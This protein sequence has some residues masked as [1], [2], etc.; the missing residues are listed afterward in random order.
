MMKVV[1]FLHHMTHIE[2]PSAVAIGNFDGMH[3]GHQAILKN[4]KDQAA[5][6]NWSSVV[7]LFEPHPKE[8][9][10]PNSSPP[11][12][13]RLT[14]KLLFLAEFG[15]DL[16]ICLKFDSK[17]ADLS[18]THFVEKIL[19]DRLKVSYLSVGEDF[20]F[21]RG[22]Q[23]NVSFL[24]QTGLLNKFEVVT[25]ST[26]FID[27]T[28]TR[29]SST[30]IRAC[31]NQG[32]LAEARELLGHPL[33]LSGRVVHGERRGREMGFPTANISLNRQMAYSGVFAVTTN[34]DG[35]IFKGVANI[36][37][38]PTIHPSGKNRF[39]EIYFFDF[40]GD[41]YGKRLQVEL[42]QKIRDEVRF[43]SLEKLK[44]QILDDVQSAK[45]L[46]K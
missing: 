38:R 15:I 16:V 9:F 46:L 43:E 31:I 11:R 35:K 8:Y 29:I 17:L 45:K 26:I 4:I 3:L 6:H 33:L 13:M 1:R 34:I 37:T 30:E 20:H 18:A 5:K 10:V 22:R 40:Y 44:A 28:E 2:R 36:G 7:I 42:V 12:L 21:G 41:L 23:G 27:E 14:D 32:K 25:Q 24:R 39:L 19:I